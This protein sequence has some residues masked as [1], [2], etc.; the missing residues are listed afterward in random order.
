MDYVR[1]HTPL[2]TNAKWLALSPKA[3]V[4]IVQAWM[5]AGANETDGF[6]PDA[7]RPVI[8][9]TPTA[10]KELEGAWWHRADG[11]WVIHDW[12]DHQVSKETL[13]VRRDAVR[14]RVQKHRR[15]KRQDGGQLHAV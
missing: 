15:G 13:D 14:Q 7:A 10:A 3:K 2:L 6:V 1:L 5:F 9:H 12:L 8:G 4:L 11:G